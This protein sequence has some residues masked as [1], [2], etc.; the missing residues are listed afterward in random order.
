MAGYFNEPEATAELLSADG[1][2]NTGD[3]GYTLDGA[4]VITGRDKDLILVN[5]R[6][7]W[8]QDLEWA[9]EE[10]DPV[11]R[12]D[13]A[14]FAVM[15]AGQEDQ[16]VVL[17]QCR[18]RD[19]DQR[20]ALSREIKGKV[21]QTAGVECAVGLIAHRGL[22]KTSSG[23]LSRTRA[24]QMYLDGVFGPEDAAVGAAPNS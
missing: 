8:P 12:G 18:L 9:V 15:E 14:A 6:N 2:L 5:G 19:P 7:I 13:V 17:V 4:L 1:W 16:V 21:R 23:K 24:R 22:P 20:A 3:L 11:R 10:L